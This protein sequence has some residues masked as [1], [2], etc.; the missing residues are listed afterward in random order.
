[1][2]VLAQLA[3]LAGQAAPPHVVQ[4]DLLVQRAADGAHRAEPRSA[5]V[6]GKTFTAIGFGK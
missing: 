1:M 2:A 6:R 3:Q 4:A 5:I